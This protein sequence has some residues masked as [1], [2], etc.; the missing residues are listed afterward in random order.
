M[1][2][3]QIFEEVRSIIVSELDVDKEKVT[4]DASLESDLGADSL[5]AVEVIMALE[6]KFSISLPD[7]V[8]M[9]LKTVSDI[10]DYIASQQK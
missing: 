6:D 8:A 1:D 3:N 9:D 2:K 5:D 4:I 10:V 7:E